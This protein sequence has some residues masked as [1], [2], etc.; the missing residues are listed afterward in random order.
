MQDQLIFDTVAKHL[1]TQKKRSEGE[2]GC[3]YRGYDGTK[4]AVGCLIKD[5]DYSPLFEGI[6]I[7]KV[8]PSD[9][10]PNMP[11]TLPEK[12]LAHAIENAVGDIT[13]TTATLLRDLQ[14]VHDT[15][16]VEKWPHHLEQ[17]AKHHGLNSNIIG[18]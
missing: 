4:C 6:G 14:Y 5:E 15:V 2:K 1:L 13:G 11:Y 17:L 7:A 10:M 16:A 9:R 8:D 3:S 18:A 12:L